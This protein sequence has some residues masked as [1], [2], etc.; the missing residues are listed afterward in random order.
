MK[1][2][3]MIIGGKEM[4]DL[5]LTEEEGQVI[6]GVLTEGTGI[7]NSDNIDEFTR[8]LFKV[9]TDTFK[10]AINIAATDAKI[11]HDLTKEI[12]K[13]TD[14][15][16]ASVDKLSQKVVDALKARQEAFIEVLKTNPDKETFIIC[17]A[18]IREATDKMDQ[19]R[20]D[21]IDF[22]DR[23]MDRETAIEESTPK[24]SVGKMVLA[25]LGG[26]A[27]GAAMGIG[28]AALYNHHQKK[29]LQGNTQFSIK[30]KIK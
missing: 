17:V 16:I 2:F 24:S 12:I 11:R 23:S 14:K 13:E 25:F 18:E 28:G 4:S 5:I 6:E 7:I 8:A 10:K 1:M 22:Y 15:S 30:G 20:K 3:Q 19:V 21:A 29:M 26:A 9:G 27:T